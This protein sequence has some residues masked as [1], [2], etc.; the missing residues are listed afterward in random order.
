MAAV[1]V[2]LAGQAP[3]VGLMTSD[4]QAFVTVTVKEHVERLPTLSEAMYVTVVEPSG[5]VLPGDC[6]ALMVTGAQASV[7]VGAV[8]DT[9]AE[10][11]EVIMEMFAG[12][13][14]IVGGVTSPAQGFVSATVTVKMQVEIL[15]RASVAV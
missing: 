12:Q 15:F 8:H 1:K 6:E 11:P 4:K 3:S 5:K 14:L 10:L 9:I 2:W 13:P 7:A